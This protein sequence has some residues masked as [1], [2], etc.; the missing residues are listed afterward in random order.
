[1]GKYKT[2]YWLQMRFFWPCMRSDIKEW[3]QCCTQCIAT[4]LGHGINKNNDL[5]FSWPITVPFWMLLHCDLWSPGNN[6]W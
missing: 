4:T 1:M 5:Y 3:T 6:A 2:L